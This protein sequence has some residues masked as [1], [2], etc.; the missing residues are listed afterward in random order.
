MS[1]QAQTISTNTTTTQTFADSFNDTI[2]KVSTFDG[3]GN[4]N[5]NLPKA[6]SGPAGLDFGLLLSGMLV[7][8]GGTALFFL[9]KKL[10]K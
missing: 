6:G 7:L 9:F 10:K 8:F 2:S 3:S 1:S 4:I 5:V